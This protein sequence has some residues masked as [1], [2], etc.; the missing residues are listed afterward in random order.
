M[1]R[2]K[3]KRKYIEEDIVE[4]MLDIT[5]NEFSPPQAAYRRG[6]PRSTLVNRLNGRGALKE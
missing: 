4:A 5:D 2:L 6:V 3:L 1:S